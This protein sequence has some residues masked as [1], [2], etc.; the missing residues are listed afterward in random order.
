L[1][2][3]RT[4]RRP[5][6]EPRQPKPKPEPPLEVEG[7]ETDETAPPAEPAPPGGMIG[8][9]GGSPGDGQREGGMIGQG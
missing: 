1:W 5:D 2:D 9:G 6:I 3:T 7:G 8:E 4:K